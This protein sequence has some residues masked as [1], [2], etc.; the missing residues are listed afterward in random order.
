MLYEIREY[1]A[2]PGRFDALIEMFNNHTIP[3]LD[4]YGIE[5][6]QAGTTWVGDNSFNEL[7][8]TLAFGGVADLESKWAQVTNDAEWLSAFA[9][10]GADGPFIHSMKRRLVDSA[11]IATGRA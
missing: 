3:A 11:A 5:L 10:I 8:Y 9:T 2:V 7:V 6:V 1:I 4:K